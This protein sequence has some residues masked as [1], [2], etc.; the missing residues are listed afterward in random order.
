MVIE[1]HF[2]FIN[3]GKSENKQKVEKKLSMKIEQK[4][5]ALSA[6]LH[7]IRKF[8]NKNASQFHGR[9]VRLIIAILQFIT[10]FNYF[11]ELA[12]AARILTDFRGR[13]FTITCTRSSG[14]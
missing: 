4:L 11:D 14:N 10:T 8:I 3:A 9:K 6:S 2:P 5:K 13:A 7:S 12:D 1:K